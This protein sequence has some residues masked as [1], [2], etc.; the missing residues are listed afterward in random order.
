MP[1][2]ACVMCIYSCHYA[3]QKGVN[4]MLIKNK[5]PMKTFGAK[6]QSALHRIMLDPFTFNDKH[7]ISKQHNSRSPAGPASWWCPAAVWPGWPQLGWRPPQ[8]PGSSRK[9]ELGN[10]SASGFLSPH[11]C[12][13]TGRAPLLS[14]LGVLMR[15]QSEW[16]HHQEQTQISEKEKAAELPFIWL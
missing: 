9:H 4:D 3:K 13:G 5:I 12:P 2:S 6:R 11:R 1:F 10:T 16:E 7:W 15:T 8:R 14:P